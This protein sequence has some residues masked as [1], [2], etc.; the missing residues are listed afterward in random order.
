[1]KKRCYYVLSASLGSKF[2][3]G[4]WFSPIFFPSFYKL[5]RTRKT[6]RSLWERFFWKSISDS[7]IWSQRLRFHY[8]TSLLSFI[9]KICD[10]VSF[11]ICFWYCH[12]SLTELYNLVQ[13]FKF[14]ASNRCIFAKMGIFWMLYMFGFYWK[15]EI[16]WP[17]LLSFSYVNIVHELIPFWAPFR[18]QNIIWTFSNHQRI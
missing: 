7:V 11:V 18:R 13:T 16:N 14:L 1:M 2:T 12:S 6:W 9:L 17:S 3:N 10:V 5:W 15:C 8:F 4:K